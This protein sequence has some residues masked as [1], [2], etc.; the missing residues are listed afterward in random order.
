MFIAQCGYSALPKS[1]DKLIF[2][3]LA[4]VCFSNGENFY[5]PIFTGLRVMSS[6]IHSSVVGTKCS[7]NMQF[8]SFIKQTENGNIR[9][10]LSPQENRLA[11]RFMHANSEFFFRGKYICENPTKPK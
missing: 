8:R 2:P 1:V 6:P 3:R 7:L 11:N 4:I 5:F 9:L 10:W